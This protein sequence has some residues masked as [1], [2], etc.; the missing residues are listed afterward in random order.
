MRLSK[1]WGIVEVVWLE[2]EGDAVEWER[3]GDFRVRMRKFFNECSGGRF[4]V[5][6]ANVPVRSH[7]ITD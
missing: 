6:R 5:P 3:E 4:D 1:V 7:G 2:E